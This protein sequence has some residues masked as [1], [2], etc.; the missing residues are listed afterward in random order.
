MNG[1]VHEGWQD[2]DRYLDGALDEAAGAKFQRALEAD[3]ELHREVERQTLLDASLK[4]LY[5]T[6]NV[7]PILEALA[8]GRTSGSEAGPVPL[9]PAGGESLRPRS[10]FGVTG[11]NARLAVAASVL[12]VLG[13]VWAF[14]T[15]SDRGPGGYQVEAWRAIDTVY[16]DEVR[17]GFKPEWVCKDDR[18]FATAF[19]RRFGQGLL[20]S[21]LPSRLQVVGMAYCNTMSPQTV[22]VLTRVD[23]REVVVFVDTVAKSP[24]PPQRSDPSGL[25]MHERQIGGLILYELTPHD[26]P[27]VLSYFYEPQMPE[28]W[29][30]A[31][32]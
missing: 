27:S 11:K 9:V 4:R 14:R 22:E 26:E 2:L 12:L 32:G 5:P 1:N 18:E 24:S 30:R 19:Y 25:R 28:E 17:R 16:R 21:A 20:L 31:R 6:P 29:K 7:D 15:F 23:G 3:P 13:G 8:N 10:R